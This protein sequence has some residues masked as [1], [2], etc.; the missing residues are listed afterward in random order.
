VSGLR[1]AVVQCRAAEVVRVDIV[2]VTA[3]RRRPQAASVTDPRSTG[4]AA[5]CFRAQVSQSDHIGPHSQ[6]IDAAYCCKCRTCVCASGVSC[7]NTAEQ[8]EM[9]FGGLTRVG[10]KNR[11]FD[12]RILDQTNPFAATR[13]DN[14]AIRPLAKLLWTLVLFIF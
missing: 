13:S 7:P 2:L 6:C 9:A 1:G 3:R 14:T 4:D 12:G 11:I 8:I 10:P 5:R